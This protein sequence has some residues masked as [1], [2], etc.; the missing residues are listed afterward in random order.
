M[1][2]LGAV[3]RSRGVVPRAGRAVPT[4]P[5][6]VR[7]RGNLARLSAAACEPLT[8]RT[9]DG[10][11]RQ[12]RPDVRAVRSTCGRF[13]PRTPVARPCVAPGRARERPPTYGRAGTF[14]RAGGHDA[15]RVEERRF[16]GALATAH[17]LRPLR[18]RL[19]HVRDGHREATAL[20]R[21]SKAPA[22]KRAGERTCRV[23]TRLPSEIHTSE[24]P[25]SRRD[26]HFSSRR[27]DSGLPSRC[28]RVWTDR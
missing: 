15:N 17:E 3:D 5:L 6:G 21:G 8:A 27:V 1:R 10:T 16:A 2:S 13:T 18:G 20:R 4:A 22:G 11:G 12:G 7:R 28:E 23:A 9:H 26:S 24:T 19:P 25:V 14:P